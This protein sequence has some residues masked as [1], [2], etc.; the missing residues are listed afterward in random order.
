MYGKSETPGIAL[1]IFGGVT[2]AYVSG[3]SIAV[4][5]ETWEQIFMSVG[6]G[7]YIGA[8]SGSCLQYFKAKSQLDK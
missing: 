5:A 3:L 7:G 6:I 4:A 2:G 8:L 1:P